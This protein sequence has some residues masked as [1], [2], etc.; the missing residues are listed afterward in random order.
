MSITSAHILVTN[1][2]LLQGIR[3]LEGMAD[4][5]TRERNVQYQPGTFCTATKRRH[6]QS[7]KQGNKQQQ[8]QQQQKALNDGDISKGHRTQLKQIPVAKT[9][10]I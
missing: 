1:T 2:I 8:Q 10:T 6:M 9:G 3:A 4:C 5:S 7:S